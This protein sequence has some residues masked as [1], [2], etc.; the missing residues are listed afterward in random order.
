MSDLMDA[1][2]LRRLAQA[3]WHPSGG[4]AT[5]LAGAGVS[6][7]AE[8][9][10]ADGARPPLWSDLARAMVEGLGGFD[11]LITGAPLRLAQTYEIAFGRSALTALVRL[12]VDDAA[13]LPGEAHVRL[14]DLPW[15]DVLTTNYDT[16]L[17][18]GA[19]RS[20]RGYGV[21][22]NEADLAGQCSPRIVKLH[23]T[24]EDEAGLV[25]TEEDYRR[26][27]EE[28][29]AMVNTA[30][31]AL[32]E[33]DLCLLGF[34]GE[35]PNFRAWIGWVRDRLK[36][37][38]RK[39]Y[40]IGPLDLDPIAR[41]VLEGL[42]VVPIDLSPV[43]PD[44]APDRHRAAIA[45]LL[46]YLEDQRPARPGDWTPLS[47]TELG[48][49]SLST[50]HDRISGDLDLKVENLRAAVRGWKRD[51]ETYPGWLVCPWEK[52]H[53]IRFGTDAPLR[54][55]EALDAIP[56]IEARDVVLEM[57]WRHDVAADPL[58]PYLATRLDDAVA[59]RMVR[60][61]N[62]VLL[63]AAIASRLR[64]ARV[65]GDLEEV[66]LKW[67]H[68]ATDPDV[69]ATIAQAWAQTALDRLDHAEVARHAEN[70]RGAD[71]VWGLRR[72]ELLAWLGNEDAA[73]SL[74][75]MTWSDLLERCRRAPSSIAL[76]SRLIWAGFVVG[77]M[78]DHMEEEVTV[79][80]P[81][82]FRLDGYDPWNEISHLDAKIRQ[83]EES[84]RKA[85][86]IDVKFRPGSYRQRNGGVRFVS[87]AA[88]ATPAELASWLRERIG[89]PFGMRH[90]NMLRTRVERAVTV[91][92]D[93]S[94]ASISRI[95]AV[96]PDTQG[97]LMTTWLKRVA[98]AALDAEEVQTLATRCEAVIEHWL[99][100]IEGPEDERGV[101]IDRIAIFVEA[102]ARLA[103]RD[104]PEAAERHAALALRIARANGWFSTS[105]AADHLLTNAVTA[106]P[107]NQRWRC[108]NTV[109]RYPVRGERDAFDSNPS[110]AYEALKG[111]MARP[112]DIGGRIAEVI[113]LLGGQ[114]AQRGGA[115]D[116]LYQLHGL[117]IL[118]PEEIDAA[119][120]ALWINVDERQL[121]DHTWLLPHGFLK[122]PAPPEVEVVDRVRRVLFDGNPTEKA[123][124]VRYGID[125]L[126]TLEMVPTEAEAAGLFDALAAWRP[127]PTE[128]EANPIA[129]SF[130]GP[131]QEALAKR[132]LDDVAGALGHA[133]WHL[134]PSDRTDAR[135]TALL[136]FV[137]ET[138]GHAALVGTLVFENQDELLR[139]LRK[140]VSRTAYAEVNSFTRALHIAVRTG[141]GVPENLVEATCTAIALQPA[142]ALH[143]LLRCAEELVAADLV[144]T[145]TTEILVE[146][147]SDLWDRFDYGALAQPDTAD[148]MLVSAT[149]V[150]AT[151]VR[152][153]LALA[154][155]GS[156]DQAVEAWRN[157]IGTDR[158][159]EVRYAL[160]E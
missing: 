91:S 17:E 66:V 160:E 61:F 54:L 120:R 24:I 159:P 133:C 117:D 111:P 128:I 136:A 31:Q 27:P 45:W 115:V 124:A 5:L 48:H 11:D 150:R 95:L 104:D 73:R 88:A 113:A 22:R 51:R 152:L 23:G 140:L 106:M 146:A 74:M 96:G 55:I 89:L 97:A 58:P 50:E 90:T 139:A 145:E 81:E 114:N 80:V 138:G 92:E 126:T 64:A 67:A 34:S 6:L 62:P 158:L 7:Q 69:A 94:A 76:R 37:L 110:G 65:V 38:E 4:A 21:V 131:S 59:K 125:P 30:R 155:K 141:S 151:A 32:I 156:S 84:R 102:L 33:T 130:L 85:T 132:L 121:P 137:Q 119:A 105:E 52:R 86:G 35:D 43:V 87:R 63:K 100:Q 18:R 36:G 82:R 8:R 157:L 68:L 19:L 129:R 98:V 142:E 72:A 40:L 154:A 135:A 41:R 42:G 3:L 77:T 103:V 75:R 56:P 12:Q 16:L 13:W 57:A 147:L 26:F 39:V 143:V 47:T 107:P 79:E 9:P 134:K 108:L 116:L 60:D 127:T 99:G 118:T 49:P 123:E 153:A 122:L 20:V 93:P 14:L 83:A 1:P 112:D 15:A 101:A 78:R 44:E 46:D 25:V 144:G 53:H 149:Y 70:V 71:P 29:A 10:E 2:S 109:I 148:R 28:R